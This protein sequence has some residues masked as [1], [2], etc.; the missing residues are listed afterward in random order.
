VRTVVLDYNGIKQV[1]RVDESGQIMAEPIEISDDGRDRPTFT[2]G[3]DQFMAL[4][5]A[6]V[7]GDR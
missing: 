7:A 4:K 6:A 3:P 5:R 2:G 1:R